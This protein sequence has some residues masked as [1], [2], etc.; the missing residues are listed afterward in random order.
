M[1]RL[2]VILSISTLLFTGCKRGGENRIIGQYHLV[3][4]YADP[5]DGNG[6]F[7]EVDS[8]KTLTFYADGRVMCNGNMCVP[9]LSTDNPTSGVYSS[10]DLLIMSDDC[11]STLRFQSF[12]DEIILEYT[13]IERCDH[14]YVRE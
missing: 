1:K 9:T 6:Y 7:T 14:K 11:S 2:L 12:G 10:D 5:G 4:V 8:D 3:Q 13:C